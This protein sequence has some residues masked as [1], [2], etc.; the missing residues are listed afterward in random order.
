[1]RWRVAADSGQCSVTMSEVATSSSTSS[2]ARAERRFDL[3]RRRPRLRVDDAHAE[4]ARAPRHRLADA[5]QPD[6]AELRAVEIERRQLLRLPA[7]P[8]P[9]ARSSPPP[10]GSRRAAASMSASVRSAVAS[11]STPGVLV[12]TMPRRAVAARS[13][14][15]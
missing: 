11:V 15:S 7:V 4:A 3:G 6:D 14:L 9:V 10:S 2:P 1:M 13:T 5:P 12:T 8:A